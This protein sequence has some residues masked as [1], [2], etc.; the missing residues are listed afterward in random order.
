MK[1]DSVTK[2]SLDV[3]ISADHMFSILHNDMT[4]QKMVYAI[5][6]TASSLSLIKSRVCYQVSFESS[7]DVFF[8][9]GFS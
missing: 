1:S 8:A 4:L 6:N 2:T 5:L 9:V 3:A 7:N